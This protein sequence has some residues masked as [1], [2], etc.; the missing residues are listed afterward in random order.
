MT[1]SE[2]LQVFFFAASPI[3]ELRGAIPYGLWVLQLPWPLVLGVSI[4]GN[5]LPV[6]FL[7][8][9]LGPISRL[10]GRVKL[11]DR[12]LNWVFERSRR[13]GKN[14]DRLEFWGLVIFV[15]IPLP[16]TGAWTGSIVAFLLGMNFWRAFLAIALGVLIAAAIVTPVA[17]LLHY[18]FFVSLPL[19]PA[20]TLVPP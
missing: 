19:E 5:I 10:A 16:L 4:A 18:A 11:L 1:P 13:R 17:M 9:L 15:G 2:F 14:I 20:N 7:L 8:L 6:P 3:A 12:I